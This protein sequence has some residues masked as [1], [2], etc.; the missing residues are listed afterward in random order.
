LNRDQFIYDNVF[1]SKGGAVVAKE[2]CI[3]DPRVSGN[4]KSAWP[5]SAVTYPAVE[6]C[7]FDPDFDPP[8]T[9][10]SCTNDGVKRADSVVMYCPLNYYAVSGGVKCDDGKRVEASYAVGTTGWKL[11]CLDGLDQ[12]TLTCIKYQ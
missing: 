3:G 6:H 10:G 4:C 9:S 7:T 11:N 8:H 12:A 5:T 1:N 2:V